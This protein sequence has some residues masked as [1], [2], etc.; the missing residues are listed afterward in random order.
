MFQFKSTLAHIVFYILLIS[1]Y[2]NHILGKGK[3]SKTLIALFCAVLLA[4]P[5]LADDTEKS[6]GAVDERIINL[7][8]RALELEREKFEYEKAETARKEYEEQFSKNC[9]FRR[10]IPVIEM[11]LSEYGVAA[12][13][14]LRKDLSILKERG[15]DK[16][17]LNVF[18]GGGSGFMGLAV[19]DVI[20]KF[21]KGGMEIET[22]AYGLVASAAVPIFVSGSKRIS[23]RSTLFMVHESAIW[24]FGFGY[25]KTTHSDVRAQKDMMDRMEEVYL[26]I[27]AENSNRDFE[28]WKGLEKQTTWFPAEQALE[29]GLVDEIQ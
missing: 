28:F 9:D 6:D 11:K 19:A 29:W 25:S 2:F 26:R 1:K 13:E 8:E 22:H 4:I 14:A 7:K 15:A 17:I 18:S 12:D 27:L 5:A 16:V 20:S 24:E 21:V 3:M 23:N 10:E